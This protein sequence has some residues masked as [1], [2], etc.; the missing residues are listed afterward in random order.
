MTV[1]TAPQRFSVSDEDGAT[2]EFVGVLLGEA[3][4]RKTRHTHGLLEE[5]S[6]R[7]SACRWTEARV[8]RIMVSGTENLPRWRGADYV[9][10]LVGRTVVHGETDRRSAWRVASPHSVIELLNSSR[11]SSLAARLALSEAAGRD[12]ALEDAY[13]NRTA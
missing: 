13:I 6:R 7:C 8:Y 2:I 9:V 4:G 3:S 12:E 10:E 1:T 5:P 11:S